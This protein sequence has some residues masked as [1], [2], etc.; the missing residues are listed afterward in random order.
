M[1]A[2]TSRPV[3]MAVEGRMPH[4]DCSA[5]EQQ[6][7]AAGPSPKSAIG[8]PKSTAEDPVVTSSTGTLNPSSADS[9]WPKAQVRLLRVQ[10]P[11]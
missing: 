7:L 6:E 5:V 9:R 2:T 1:G 4:V 11:W 10:H 8:A 3:V